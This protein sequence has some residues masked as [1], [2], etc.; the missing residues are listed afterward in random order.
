MAEKDHETIADIIA[1]MRTPDIRESANTSSTIEK[2]AFAYINDFLKG[3]ADRLEAA[4]KRELHA[5]DAA[6]LRE[7][8]GKLLGVLYNMGVDENTL[9]IAIA[10]PNCH[11][12]SE[13][14][15]SVLK[16]ARAALAAPA[17]NCDVGT[18][19]EQTQRYCRELPFPP[20]QDDLEYWGYEHLLRWAQ[21]PYEEG[22]KEWN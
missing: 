1:D 4:H 7:A 9:T 11:M 22:G 20:E 16:D 19:E 17:R 10:S 18:A 2:R 12:N 21:M 8:V 3:Y 14:T 6:K 5:G 15:L 13:H